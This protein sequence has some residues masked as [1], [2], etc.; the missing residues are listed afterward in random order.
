RS[1]PPPDPSCGAIAH[2]WMGRGMARSRRVLP[3]PEGPLIAM[4]SPADNENEADLRRS[5]RRSRNLKQRHTAL[6]SRGA[7]LVGRRRT[8]DQGALLQACL[9][10]N[11]A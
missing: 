9:V 2:R 8:V 11:A 10:E 3:L 7:R 5:V 6:S 4:D 1:S